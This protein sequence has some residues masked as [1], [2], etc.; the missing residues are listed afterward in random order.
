[1]ITSFDVPGSLETNAWKV[2]ALGEII[3][4]F[5]YAD[6]INHL[7]ILQDGEF[8]IFDV[9]GILPLA[10]DDGGINARGTSSACIAPPHPATSRAP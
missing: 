1:V 9:P 6:G 8:T 7:F 5:R 4:G 2:N 10:Q 3:G